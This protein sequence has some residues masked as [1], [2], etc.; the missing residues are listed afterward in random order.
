MIRVSP[1]ELARE[2]PGPQASSM[3]TRAPRRRRWSAVQPPKAPAPTTATWGWDDDTAAYASRSHFRALPCA[4]GRGLLSLPSLGAEHLPAGVAVGRRRGGRGGRHHARARLGRPG[5]M[6]PGLRRA[7]RLQPSLLGEP[8]Q[9]L[10]DG[11]T[12]GR[13]AGGGR[14]LLPAAPYLPAAPRELRPRPRLQ[15]APR[16]GSAALRRREERRGAR[17]VPQPGRG[18]GPAPLSRSA[19]RAVGGRGAGEGSRE[20]ERLAAAGVDGAR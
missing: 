13:G 9:D 12:L 17:A 15:S 11:R 20:G 6:E 14:A 5:G 2:L 3:V 4:D 1:P 16:H 19:R 18:K 7:P 8:G 10:V